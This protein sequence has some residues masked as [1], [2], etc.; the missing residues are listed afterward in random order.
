M[1][2][3]YK[4]FPTQ[5]VGARSKPLR[6]GLTSTWSGKLGGGEN[7]YGI[8]INFDGATEMAAPSNNSIAFVLVKCLYKKDM[9]KIQEGHQQAIE[10]YEQVVALLDN[11]QDSNK[12]PA[13]L[14]FWITG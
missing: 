8:F 14:K 13:S 4:D 12:N 11:L 1:S 6:G 3:N 9:E 5:Y 2:D 7:P 10:E